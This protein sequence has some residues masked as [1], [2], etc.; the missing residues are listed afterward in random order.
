MTNSKF[1]KLISL[2]VS[3]L[4]LLSVC[5]AVSA[6]NGAVPDLGLKGS[7]SVTVVDKETGNPLSGEKFRLYLIAEAYTSGQSLA[8][9]YTASF[10]NNGMR[11]DDRYAFNLPNHLAYYAERMSLPH[12][13][14]YTDTK[15][16][17]TFT[18]LSAGLYLVV[19]V[20]I[21]SLPF[22]V[23]VPENI[24]GQ[25]KYDIDA[26]P[27][28]EGDKSEDGDK[29]ISVEKKWQTDSHPNSVVIALLKDGK[30]VASEILTAEKGWKFTWENLDADYSWT[31]LEKDV[32][33]GFNV[34][35]ELIGKKTVIT[36]SADGYEE[37]TTSTGDTTYPQEETTT[38]T[39]DTTKP[40]HTDNTTEPD[41]GSNTETSEGTTASDSGKTTKP[42]GS[43]KPTSKGETTTK[44]QLADTGQLN[45][46]IPVFAIAGLLLFS[47]GWA[48]LNL[49]KDEETVQ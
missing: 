47:I 8:F 36:N 24:D 21:S 49:K 18:D 10:A 17:V 38:S 30:E 39:D 4:I 14:K 27:K 40:S 31:V 1:N 28:V 32:P 45:W 20:E 13:E 9:K 19:P 44:E 35:Y 23:S 43:T 33:D 15:G 48:M 34:S 26:S 46:P 22:L 25:W 16:T 42:Q 41:A 37:T 12:Q 29:D 3:A 5:F 7:I 2:F 11:L 6:E